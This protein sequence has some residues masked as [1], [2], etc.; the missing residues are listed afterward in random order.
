MAQLIQPSLTHLKNWYLYIN[1][2]WKILGNGLCMSWKFMTYHDKTHGFVMKNTQISSNVT[3]HL[4]VS[5]NV[6]MFFLN[7]YCNNEIKSWIPSTWCH[8]MSCSI[9]TKYV[10]KNTVTLSDMSWKHGVVKPIHRGR[11]LDIWE[12]LIDIPKVLCSDKW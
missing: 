10:K 4:H 12:C 5:W 8:Q 9:I 11:S 7:I 3:K 1:A 2:S 6:I